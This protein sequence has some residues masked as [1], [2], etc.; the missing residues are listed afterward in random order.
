MADSWNPA[1]HSDYINQC[2]AYCDSHDALWIYVNE[3]GL[4][5]LRALVENGGDNVKTLA[6]LKAD[7]E[8]YRRKQGEN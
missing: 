5:G 8:R 3:N 2:K 6:A 1:E 4:D 7:P